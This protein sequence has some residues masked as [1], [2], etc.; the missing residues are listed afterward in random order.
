MPNRKSEQG[1]AKVIRERTTNNKTN[2]GVLVYMVRVVLCLLVH[3]DHNVDEEVVMSPR[4]EEET[5]ALFLFRKIKYDMNDVI[6]LGDETDYYECDYSYYYGSH[7]QT[8]SKTAFAFSDPCGEARR[9]MESLRL[10]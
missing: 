5:N 6:V 3:N 10:G 1:A 8:S 9:D 7:A 4:K 2:R